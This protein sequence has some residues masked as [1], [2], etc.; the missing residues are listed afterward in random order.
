MALVAG[1]RE[2]AVEAQLE[3]SAVIG[4]HTVDELAAVYNGCGPEWLPRS[5][6]EFLSRHFAEF[7]PAFLVHDWDFAQSDGT[8]LSFSRANDRLE[9][10][11]RRLADL[12]HPW[13]SWR[14]YALRLRAYA[15]ADA[16]RDCGWKAWKDAYK[17]H[18]EQQRIGESTMHALK[19][20]DSRTFKLSNLLS[21]ALC[22]CVTLAFAGCR[23][24]EVENRGEAV[25]LGKDGAPVVVAGKPVKYSLGWSVY[26]NQHWMVTGF[27][28][29]DAY[30]RGEDIGVKLNGYNAEPSAELRLLVEAS[31]KGAA[32]L[33]AKIGAAVATSGGSVAG[34]AGAS[35]LRQ[36]IARFIGKGG[37]AKN[38]TV[39]CKD[40]TCSITDGTVT[41]TCTDCFER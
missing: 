22:L 36:A 3:G 16:C 19:P 30:V 33:A 9:R 35:L 12:A 40:G 7:A 41:E 34:E 38:A 10:N 17:A 13:Y 14:R 18:T 23:V 29:L 20:S 1:L 32:E 26:H 6:R 37:S 15:I 31:L 24:V 21:V 39:T 27:D 25:L 4:A 5:V 8:R 2:R 11:C 28:S